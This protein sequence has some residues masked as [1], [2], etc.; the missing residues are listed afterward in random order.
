MTIIP[1]NRIDTWAR[2][3]AVA[4]GV[5][6]FVLMMC[7]LTGPELAPLGVYLVDYPAY[8]LLAPLI[9]ESRETALLL[10]SA[11]VCSILYP[12]TLYYLF[13]FVIRM[14]RRNNTVP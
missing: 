8:W 6:H 2:L 10:A 4:I 5:L 12:L 13:K 3:I 14:I 9:G 11:A 7:F 1:R